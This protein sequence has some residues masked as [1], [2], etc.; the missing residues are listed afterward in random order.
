MALLINLANL[1]PKI[2]KSNKIKRSHK[3]NI[4]L[5]VVIYE[6]PKNYKIADQ[7]VE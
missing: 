1:K 2:S 7:A 6:N 3:F 5:H 4:Q